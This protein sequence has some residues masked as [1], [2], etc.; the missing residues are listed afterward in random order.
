MWQKQLIVQHFSVHVRIH[1]I[2]LKFGTNYFCSPNA[3][4]LAIIIC[5]GVHINYIVEIL[6]L[7]LWEKMG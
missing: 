1:K 3:L 6:T 4:P 5:S 2:Q 7:K